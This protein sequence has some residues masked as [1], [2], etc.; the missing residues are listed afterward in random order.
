M[1]GFRGAERLA[2]MMDD[3]PRPTARFHLALIRE[4]EEILAIG[5]V[6][7]R[8]DG[9]QRNATGML[10]R[11]DREHS[12]RSGHRNN[13]CREDELRTAAWTA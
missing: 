12:H 1:N 9:H 6:F 11:V 13:E 4:G 8:R 7:K 5:L 10:R 3:D 2:Q